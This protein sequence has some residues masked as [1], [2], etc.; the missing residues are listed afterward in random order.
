MQDFLFGDHAFWQFLCSGEAEPAT[1][2]RATFGGQIRLASTQITRE[3]GP[4]GALLVQLEWT[5][6]RQPDQDYAVFVQL[7]D[8]QGRLV[9]Q[10][11]GPPAGGARPTTNWAVGES[12]AD[13]H[14]ALIP[15]ELPAGTYQL[16]AGLYAGNA[17]L[18][19]E[20]GE[21]FTELASVSF[22]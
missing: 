19:I 22:A 10:H 12:V 18:P 15:P 9:A 17:R 1:A 4:R 3:R 20:S 14:L 6:V 13:R 11:D 21:S 5:A 2:R 8:G 7:I 16:I